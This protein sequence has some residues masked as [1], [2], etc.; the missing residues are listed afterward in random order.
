MRFRNPFRSG[1]SRRRFVAS[2]ADLRLELDQ[3]DGRAAKHD[4]EIADRDAVIRMLKAEL[5][6]L[7]QQNT[8]LEQLAVAE[9]HRAHA[10]DMAYV[11]LL[12]TVQAQTEAELTRITGELPADW[13]TSDGETTVETPIPLPEAPD[14][15]VRPYAPVPLHESPHAA[16][17][18]PRE[19]WPVVRFD[20]PM[21]V[22]R[23]V[24][25]A[26]ATAPTAVLPAVTVGADTAT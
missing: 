11:A 1:T 12:E 14:T 25:V 20:P 22:G 21:T 16:D 7:D 4:A 17:S 2:R 19:P 10:A 18:P 6:N 15:V 23:T 26:A 9:A 24:R 13:L 5:A 8:L 3:A